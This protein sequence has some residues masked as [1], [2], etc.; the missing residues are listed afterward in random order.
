[1]DREREKERERK[2][3]QHFFAIFG[4]FLEN[5]DKPPLL[6]DQNLACSVITE[7]HLMRR[8]AK[9]KKNERVETKATNH[10]KKQK[11]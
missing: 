8:M 1:M 5:V 11:I 4:L 9:K 7:K 3:S 6:C 10:P 2:A